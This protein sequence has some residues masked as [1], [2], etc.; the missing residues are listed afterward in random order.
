MSNCVLPGKLMTDRGMKSPL[1]FA[2]VGHLLGSQ[3][4]TQGPALQSHLQEE[5]KS[6][7]SYGAPL[8]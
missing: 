1:R 4:D 6:S 2:E 7:R 8:R 5:D 3:R